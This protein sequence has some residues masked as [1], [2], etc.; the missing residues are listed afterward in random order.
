MMPANFANKIERLFPDLLSA[1]TQDTLRQHGFQSG[2]LFLWSCRDAGQTFRQ[3]AVI[4][5]EP[6]L[7]DL[8][9]WQSH[10][11]QLPY[12]ATDFERVSWLPEELQPAY[13]RPLNI[14]GVPVGVLIGVNNSPAFIPESESG[15]MVASWEVLSL[16]AYAAHLKCEQAGHALENV[17]L[18]TR[19]RSRRQ[20][21]QTLQETSRVISSSLDLNLVLDLILRELG[22]VVSYDNV[23]LKRVGNDVAQVIAARGFRDLNS[24]MKTI[25]RVSEN[26]LASMIVYEQQ[27]VCIDDINEDPRW[28]WLPGTHTI[29]SWIGVPLL[30]KDQAI[31]LLSVSRI[32]YAPFTEDEAEM[33]ASFA[34]HAAIAIENARLY[35]ELKEFSST[36]EVRVK[37]RTI[38]LERARQ[39]LAIALN[40]EVEVQENERIRIANELHDGVIQTLIA[41]NFQLQTVKLRV[42][43][44]TPNAYSQLAEVQRMLGT[45]VAD[46][47]AIVH[48]L[49][50]P[51]LESLG[52]VRAIRQLALQFHKPPQFSAQ[53]L[54]LGNVIPLSHGTERTVYRVIQ[55][56]LTNSWKHSLAKH[57]KITI[58]FQTSNLE[59]ILQD[60]G[61]GFDPEGEAGTG[62]GLISMRDR[63]R[64]SGG[65]LSIFSA[66]QSGTRI[67]LQ[68]PI[69]AVDL[70]TA[71]GRHEP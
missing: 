60:D 25:Y 45:L 67:E 51:V 40:R 26:T 50:P 69:S 68:L 21:I 58:L 71:E 5:V 19:E 6:E 16:A 2:L 38:Q 35:N 30:M 53:V 62:I 41:A 57:F 47:K 54:V 28:L 10:L 15:Q 14:D 52:L 23:R 39:E 66:P 46:T 63:A 11:Q 44:S 34:N 31:G 4:G 20:M 61:R 42:G 36:L 70:S 1:I 7:I 22:R 13:L 17:E 8:E 33:V 32:E 56:A 9:A 29:C 64:S 24:V 55:E 48:D 59:V 37:E 43:N 65:T 27:T 12:N 3:G 18:L 49:R